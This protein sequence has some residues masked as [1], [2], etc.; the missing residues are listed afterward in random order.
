MS[1]IIAPASGRGP[2]QQLLVRGEVAFGEA[3][4]G[5][6]HVAGRRFEHGANRMDRNPRH[7][8]KKVSKH[9]AIWN[10]P[11]AQSSS[12]FLIDPKH[13]EKLT[14]VFVTLPAYG[15]SIPFLMGA[16]ATPKA[17]MD[18]TV[19][20]TQKEAFRYSEF[21]EAGVNDEWRRFIYAVRP[22]V[23]KGEDATKDFNDYF[24]R[25]VNLVL[26]MNK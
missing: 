3:A 16:N 17:L 12:T 5:H 23:E 21:Y 15:Y 1:S 26:S 2:R 6:I 14:T 4:E 24:L 9:P 20:R 19:Y 11:R 25:M 10:L 22:K 13:P 7:L 8:V 18:G